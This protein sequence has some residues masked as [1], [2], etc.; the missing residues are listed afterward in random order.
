MRRPRIKPL[1]LT[2]A[3]LTGSL[4]CAGVAYAASL[5]VSSR[6]LHAWS[7]TLTKAS[8]NQS[9]TT[10]SDTYVDQQSPNT[11]FGGSTTLSVGGGSSKVKYAFIRFDLTNCNLPTSGGA[12][13]ATL[14]LTVTS[15]GKDTISLYPVTSSWSPSTLTWNGVTGLTIGTTATASFSADKALAYTVPVTADVDMAIKSGTLW[16][17]ELKDTSGTAVTSLAS[18]ENTTVA[19][20]PSLT[21]SDEK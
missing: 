5:G 10:A 21:L 20:R 14:T 15:A 8:C 7:Q 17:W 18:A 19:S 9:Y 3:V 12:D 6:Q 11:A 16:G 2:V 1:R 13:S 4:S